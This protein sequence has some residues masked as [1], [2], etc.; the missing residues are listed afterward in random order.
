MAFG[1]ASLVV[2]CAGARPTGN[3]NV[4]QPAKPVD[5][6]RYLGR[7]YELG[8]YDAWF[9]RGCEG[10]TADYS[11][12]DD[13]LVRVLNTCHAGAVDGP[14]RASEGKAKVVEGSGN[15]KLKVS[16]FGPFYIGDYWVLDHDDDYAWS[17]VGEPSGKYLWILSRD[18]VPSEQ[19]RAALIERVRR[20]GYDTSMIRLTR[21]TSSLERVPAT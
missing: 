5:L 9:E 16:F 8:R 6:T 12:R 3:A 14:I 15:A 7:W 10:A 1:V 4:P 19:D 18:P 11:L 13:G 2:A 21:Q 20:L 17:I